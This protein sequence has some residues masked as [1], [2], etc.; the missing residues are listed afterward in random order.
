MS[1]ED[2]LAHEG[3]SSQVMLTRK[4]VS[5]QGTLARDYVL[6]CRT[7]SLADSLKYN[8]LKFSY[9]SFDNNFENEHNIFQLVYC[10]FLKAYFSG[11]TLIF[12]IQ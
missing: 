3:V 12:I 8:T 10:T 2:T 7:R 5:T 6:V 9:L 4:H 11:S 1:T